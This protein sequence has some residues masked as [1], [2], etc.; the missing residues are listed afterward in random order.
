MWRTDSLWFETAIVLGIFAVGNILFGHFQQHNPPVRR[1]G[2]V[3]LVLG[4]TL[5]LSATAGRFWGLGWLLLP[6]SAAAYVHLRW[7]SMH[8]INGWTGE[9]REQYLALI[10]GRRRRRSA[11]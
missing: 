6:L 3:G 7:L 2:K 9:P 10:A 5:A 4:I 8:G 1:L 11:P